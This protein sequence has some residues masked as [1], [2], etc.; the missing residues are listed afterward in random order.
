MFLILLDVTRTF[1]FGTPTPRQSEIYTRVLKGHMGIDR[2]IFPT[3]TP[4]CLL[5]SFAREH[6]WQVGL[7]FIHGK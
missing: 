6:L 3:G 7:N 5:D 2:Q 1:H 4:G